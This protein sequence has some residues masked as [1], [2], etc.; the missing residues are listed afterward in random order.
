MKLL[1]RFF[2]LML[3]NLMSLP[4]LLMAQ[5][6]GTYIDD[7]NVQDS[8]YMEAD[9]LAGVEEASGSNTTVIIIVAVVVIAVV[10]FFL[11][12]KKKK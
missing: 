8:S 3:L 9:P 12:R 4:Y 5:D 1:K 6:E 10:A 11:L 7:M 2:A